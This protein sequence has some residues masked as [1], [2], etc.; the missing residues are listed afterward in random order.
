MLAG[1]ALEASG[2]P[3]RQR[4]LRWLLAFTIAWLVADASA[5]PICAIRTTVT[6]GDQLVGADRVLLVVRDG[7]EWATEARIKGFRSAPPEGMPPAPARG[8]VLVARGSD[9]GR[10]TVLGPVGITHVPLL[11]R[12]SDGKRLEAMTPADWRERVQLFAPYL[13]HEERLLAEL[14]YDEIARAPYAAMRTLQPTLDPARIRAWLAN[15]H[16]SHRVSLYTLLLGVAG[17]AESTDLV[18]SGIVQRRQQHSAD[19]LAAL[20]GADLEMR[21]TAALVD[22]ERNY[23]ADT[24]RELPEVQAALL[25]LSVQ[26]NADA[27]VPQSQIVAT[28][29]RM[30]TQRHPLSGLAAGDLADWKVWDVTPD[31]VALLQSPDALHPASR[32]AIVMYL[33]RSPHP[34]A[35]A[36]SL[37]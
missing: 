22:V 2:K 1:V 25:A 4:W 24:T 31:Y 36:A 20:L 8:T 28:Y 3:G 14:A 30:I 5:C 19:N 16:L 34:A 15:P 7:P 23:L 6:M 29:R 9:T 26:G 33:L 21:S 32:F 13:E 17:G 27:V 10:W 11:R 35:K 12:V 18:K 37:R